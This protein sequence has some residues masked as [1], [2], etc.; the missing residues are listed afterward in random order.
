MSPQ[1]SV[2]TRLAQRLL[3]LAFPLLL[4]AGCATPPA[5]PPKPVLVITEWF[6]RV[7][8]GPWPLDVRLV[9]YDNG[10]VLA[11][12]RPKETTEV[13]DFIWSQM[14]P[15]AVFELAAEAKDA[16]LENV[17]ITDE[18]VSLPLHIGITNIDHWDPDKSA[19]SRLQAYGAPC[20]SWSGG[21]DAP[22]TAALRAATDPRFLVLCERLLHLQLPNAQAWQPTEMTVI[23]F[24]EDK[25]SDRI[26]PW[27]AVWPKKWRE[28]NLYG[29]RAIEVCVPVGPNP[30]EL[31][32]QILDMNSKQWTSRAPS[33]R[34]PDANLWSI[35]DAA[36]K[37]SIPGEIE[38]VAPGPCSPLHR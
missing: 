31:T 24:P 23:L 35:L 38:D 33:V 8:P 9:A 28:I 7:M 16:A 30:D 25:P 36:A 4:L 17:E 29:H 14:T 27:P 15:G 2:V 18:D 21:E 32:A 1:R 3:P 19:F 22:W 6:D 11:Q 13:P 37:V 20:R 10:L 34:G 5:A 12:P 26:I